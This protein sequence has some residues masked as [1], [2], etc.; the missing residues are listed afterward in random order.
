MIKSTPIPRPTAK[1]LV[2]ADIS[3]GNLQIEHPTDKVLTIQILGQAVKAVAEALAKQMVEAAAHSVQV[4]PASVLK[5][6]PG[7]RN[8]TA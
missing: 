7:G 4:A 5:H 3:T 6:I 2:V 8:G 1:I